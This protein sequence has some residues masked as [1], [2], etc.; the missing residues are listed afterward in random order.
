MWRKTLNS[1]LKDPTGNVVV[2][3]LRYA[4][5]GGVAFVADF[6]LLYV[7][8]DCAHVHY[9]LSAILSFCVGLLITYLLS[10][11][12]IFDKRRFDSRVPEIIIFVLIGLVGLLITA[13]FMWLFTD[14]LQIHYLLSKVL[15]TFVS[16]VWNF[17]AKKFIL[18]SDRKGR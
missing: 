9:L 2:Q 17:L 18:F 1:L 3:A 5:S 4:V 12:W 13:L 16:T 15:T 7:L 8:T 11:Y 14:L 10:V 6:L